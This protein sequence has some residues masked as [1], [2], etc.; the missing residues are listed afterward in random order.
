ML[1]K[2]Q[3][4]PRGNDGQSACWSEKNLRQ[5]RVSVCPANKPSVFIMSAMGQMRTAL[6][7]GGCVRLSF[8]SRRRADAP[9]TSAMGP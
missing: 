5:K 1:V 6:R 2:M 8:E 3:F 9:N 4:C 7:G